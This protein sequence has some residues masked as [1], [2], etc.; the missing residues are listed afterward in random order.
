[1]QFRDVDDLINRKISIALRKKE[2]SLVSLQRQIGELKARLSELENQVSKRKTKS[3][4]S[5]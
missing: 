1:M 4:S 2:S 3:I 5:Q